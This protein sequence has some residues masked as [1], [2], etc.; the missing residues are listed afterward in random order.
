MNHHTAECAAIQCYVGDPPPCDCGFVEHPPMKIWI[1][2]DLHLGEDRME[3]MGRPFPSA[4]AHIEHIVSAF[5]SK[6]AKTDLLIINGDVCYQKSPKALLHLP[7]INGKKILIRG[8]H[9]R[10]FTDEELAPY[11]CMVIP[12]G[13]GLALTGPD[14]L[15]LWVTHYPSLSRP[16]YFNLVGHI[17]SSWKVQLN[18]L[19]VGVDVHHFYPVALDNVPFFVKAVSEFYDNDVWVADHPANAK[20]KGIRGKN[21]TYF[22]GGTSSSVSEVDRLKIL[23]VNNLSRTLS[24]KNV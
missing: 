7:E 16:D 23:A 11:F 2:A 19:N 9:D 5:N 20:F 8:N 15:P 3:I 6:V 13:G 14:N 12:E 22:K 17:H 18:M 1:S 10:V 21:E 4:S 24:T